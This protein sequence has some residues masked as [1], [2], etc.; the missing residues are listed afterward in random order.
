MEGRVKRGE[1]R[2]CISDELRSVLHIYTD[3]AKFNYGSI[4]IIFGRLGEPDRQDGTQEHCQT[5]NRSMAQL[6][7][8]IRHGEYFMSTGYL[9]VRFQKVGDT[10]IH[11]FNNKLSHT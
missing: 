5:A 9:H 2:K 11:H 10:T 3:A 6:V 7:L 8:G 4:V 1:A